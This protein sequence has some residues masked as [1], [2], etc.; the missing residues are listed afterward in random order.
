MS[1]VLIEKYIK[2][3][4]DLCKG[5][6][7]PRTIDFFLDL[8][9]TAFGVITRGSNKEKKYYTDLL[10]RHYINF[11]EEVL[12]FHDQKHHTKGQANRII[13]DSKIFNNQREIDYKGH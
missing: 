11:C 3:A 6:T 5:Y 9:V 12:Y 8:C 7:V 4:K 10:V 2:E 1:D 13:F